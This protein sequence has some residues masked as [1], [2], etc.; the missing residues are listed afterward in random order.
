MKLFRVN[1]AS[2]VDRL[3]SAEIGV[4]PRAAAVTHTLFFT[5]KSSTPLKTT[6]LRTPPKENKLRSV[7]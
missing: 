4:A 7:Q 5:S 6:L 2:R 1:L 3:T